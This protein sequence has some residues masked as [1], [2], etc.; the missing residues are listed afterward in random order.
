MIVDKIENLGNYKFLHR[1]IASLQK[2]IQTIYGEAGSTPLTSSVFSS[3]VVVNCQEEECRGI[4][5]AK[6][7]AHK[8]HIDIHIPLT[9]NEVIGY[10]CVSDCEMQEEYDGERDLVFYKDKYETQV[11]VPLGYFAVCMPQ[12]GH[13]PLIGQGKERKLIV[14][15]ELK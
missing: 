1:G 5:C 6:L 4:E 11:C 7:E 15:I 13:A 9:Q 8:R 2:Y 12:D 14:K 10:K 3:D